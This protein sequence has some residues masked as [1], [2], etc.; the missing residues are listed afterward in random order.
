MYIHIVERKN[1]VIA[2]STQKTYYD[3]SAYHH[4][5]SGFIVA[6]SCP[7]FVKGIINTYTQDKCSVV[8]S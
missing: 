7:N 8:F 3:Q 4:E 6:C 2:I 1:V 5:N